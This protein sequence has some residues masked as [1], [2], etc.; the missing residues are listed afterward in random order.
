MGAAGFIA[1]NG[2][3]NEQYFAVTLLVSGVF[4]YTLTGNHIYHSI[5]NENKGSRSFFKK[6]DEESNTRVG[7]GLAER[8]IERKVLAIASAIT[9][10]VTVWLVL[11]LYLVRH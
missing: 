3:Y 1:A 5:F 10:A 11:T 7:T 9:I 2:I 4:L 8:D 6:I